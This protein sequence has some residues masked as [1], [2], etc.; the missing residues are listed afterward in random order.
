LN[1]LA[2]ETST[3]ACSAA[4]LINGEI[5]ERFEFA[6]RGHGDLIL[7]MV[8]DLLADA[9]LKPQQLTAIAFGRG[10]GA[11][12]GVRIATSVV[13]GIALG[14]DLPVVPVSTLAALAQG[15]YRLHQHHKLLCAMDARMGE[16][17]WG[18]Y[19]IEAGVALAQADECVCPAAAAPAV[20]GGEWQGVGTGWQVYGD[21]LVQRYGALASVCDTAALPRARDVALLA[22]HGYRNGRAV[23]AE[24]ALPVY[25][26]DNVV[27]RG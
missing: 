7:Q 20:S 4:L 22:E 8:D 2:I 25:L 9:A 16:I 21:A 6:P 14:A 26:R 27:S 10:P 15:A 1:I 17:Y 13:Q 19:A 24:Q 5:E 3:E 23:S 18:A 11:F 12:T